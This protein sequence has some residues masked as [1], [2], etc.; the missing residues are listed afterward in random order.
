MALCG[1]L[2]RQDEAREWIAKLLAVNPRHTIAWFH[3]Y[4]SRF[5]SPGTLAVWEEGLRRAGLPEE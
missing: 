3:A 5:M 2:G 1:Y 4:A